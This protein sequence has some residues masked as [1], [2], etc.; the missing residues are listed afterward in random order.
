M[1]KPIIV[2]LVFTL[3]VNIVQA[4]A[5][6]VYKA[7]VGFA[8]GGAW[9]LGDLNEVFFANERPMIGLFIKRIINGHYAIKLQAES[10]EIGIPETNNP[11]TIRNQSITDLQVTG[12]FNFFNFRS[13]SYE[14]YASDVSPY[15]FLGIG[16]SLF[17]GN[18]AAS[19]PFGAGV[20][21]KLSERINLGAYWSMDKVLS[22]N[23][24]GVDNPLGLNEG[25]W[26]NRDWYS[27]TMLYISFN[28]FKI[29]VP[30]RNG[31]YNDKR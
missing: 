12:E 23:L 20:K 13:K 25:F 2:L 7:E 19:I 16:T 30:C 27:T 28:L 9:Y 8:G 3:F 5:Q 21:L 6:N 18:I 1:Q 22:D 10:G 24:D 26:N 15:I 17:N 11:S 29:C 14:P 31:I 4:E